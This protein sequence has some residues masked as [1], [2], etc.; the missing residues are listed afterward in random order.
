MCVLA[1]VLRGS[2]LPLL[3]VR[4]SGN[5]PRCERSPSGW[6]RV[7]LLAR[8]RGRGWKRHSVGAERR[9]RHGARAQGSTCRRTRLCSSLSFAL[10][11]A[12]RCFASYSRSSVSLLL[13]T[14]SSCSLSS[15]S[16]NTDPHLL[17]PLVSSVCSIVMFTT[18]CLASRRLVTSCISPITCCFYAYLLALIR[19]R[20]EAL[21]SA[22]MRWISAIRCLS[23]F[24]T[25]K[26]TS[27]FFFLSLA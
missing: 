12:S 6:R 26:R 1:P 19:T 15:R 9:V 21:V 8:P 7:V 22:S 5:T 4:W 18:S 25:R 14:S 3:R 13:F 27:S 16:A 17:F 2:S 20:S 11:I 24:L 10:F 23:S